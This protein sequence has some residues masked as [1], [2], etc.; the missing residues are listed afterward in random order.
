MTPNAAH[1]AA[2]PAA[3]LG[4]PLGRPLTLS[5]KLTLGDRIAETNARAAQAHVAAR[6]RLHAALEDLGAAWAETQKETAR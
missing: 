6:R 1:L 4:R 3:A 5:E 2:V